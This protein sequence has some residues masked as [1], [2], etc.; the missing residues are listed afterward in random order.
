[1]GLFQ[2][3]AESCT[4]SF[5]PPV[6]DAFYQW[7]TF[8]QW[9]TFHN[10]GSF[11]SLGQSANNE[12]HHLE[13]FYKWGNIPHMGDIPLFR[14]IFPV[15]VDFRNFNGEAHRTT[16]FLDRKRFEIANYI[17]VYYGATLVV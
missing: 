11:D 12:F 3:C 17:G 10:W 14:D 13:S 4:T 15:F 1:M 9:L 6:G 5:F 8:Y 7:G 2:I 16:K